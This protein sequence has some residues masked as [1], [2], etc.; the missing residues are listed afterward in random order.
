M[1]LMSSLLHFFSLVALC[2]LFVSGRIEP[3]FHVYQ[4]ISSIKNRRKF[5]QVARETCGQSMEPAEND[6][7]MFGEITDVRVKGK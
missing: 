3:G 2:L 6:I 1:H 5:R 7:V 4:V